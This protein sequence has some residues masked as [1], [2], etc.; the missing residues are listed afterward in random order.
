[1]TW[2][3]TITTLRSRTAQPRRGHGQHVGQAATRCSTPRRAATAAVGSRSSTALI[4]P[5]VARATFLARNQPAFYATCECERLPA[6]LR[7]SAHP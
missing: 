4:D 6:H 7:E 1:M 3:A 5:E 2:G